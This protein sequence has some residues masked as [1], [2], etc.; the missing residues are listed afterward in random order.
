LVVP[1]RSPLSA[2]ALPGPAN[3]AALQAAT[4]AP[5][6][7]LADP[8][9]ALLRERARLVAYLLDDVKRRVERAAMV[10]NWAISYVPS[11]RTVDVTGQAAEFLRAELARKTGL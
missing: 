5:Q 4:P 2:S 8:T 6:N 1:A 3:L 9:S 11:S 10:K 7:A